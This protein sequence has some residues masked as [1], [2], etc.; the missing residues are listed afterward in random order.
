MASITAQSIGE[1]LVLLVALI[2]KDVA[3]A[4]VALISKNKAIATPQVPKIGP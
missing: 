4:V 1:I 2:I 3:D